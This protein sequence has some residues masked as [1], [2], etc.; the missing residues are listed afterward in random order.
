MSKVRTKLIEKRVQET[1][2]QINSSGLS[3]EEIVIYLS[4]IL[5]RIGYSLYYRYEK[6][7]A[8]RPTTKLS[9]AEI[10]SLWLAD[11]TPGSSL[12]KMGFDVHDVLLRRS[13]RQ[14]KQ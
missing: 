7:D 6:P 3:R 9:G 10:E 12:M 13:R 2:A 4:E 11:P 14:N 5:T 8:T 1:L